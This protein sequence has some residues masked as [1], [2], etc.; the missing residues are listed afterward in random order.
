MQATIEKS[1]GYRDFASL[2][3][4]EIE[5]QYVMKIDRPESIRAYQKGS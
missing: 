3:G 4:T 2:V 1:P 5:K